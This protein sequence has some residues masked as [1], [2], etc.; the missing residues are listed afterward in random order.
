MRMLRR[1]VS[2]RVAVLGTLAGL[3]AGL[4]LA[5]VVLRPPSGLG[6]SA[7]AAPLAEKEGG[8]AADGPLPAVQVVTLHPGLSAAA[9]ET[10]VTNRIERWVNQAPALRRVDSHTIAGVSIV[11]AYFDKDT[12]PSTAFANVNSLA[13]AALPLLPANTLPPVV[14]PLGPENTR[15]LGLLAVEGPILNGRLEKGLPE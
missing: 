15:P 3:A 1:A 8:G 2:N 12:A 11:R 5:L 13:L 14:L 4:G 10:T 6:G 7:A 9:M